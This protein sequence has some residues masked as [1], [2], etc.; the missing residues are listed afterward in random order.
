MCLLNRIQKACQEEGLQEAVSASEDFWQAHKFQLV[1]EHVCACFLLQSI[2]RRDSE[3]AQVL[4]QDD[5][6]QTV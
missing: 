5:Y 2:S 4:A 6:R 3:N 1:P